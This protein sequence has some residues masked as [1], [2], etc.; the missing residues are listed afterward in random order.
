MPTYEYA[1]DACFVIYKTRHGIEDPPPRRCP[2]CAGALRKLLAAPSL[3]TR[4]FKSPTE[5]KYARLS[6]SDEI[7]REKELQKVFQTIW[8]PSEVKHSPWDEDH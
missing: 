1:C 7:A 2:E 4:N 8:L 6:E 3:N 5:A